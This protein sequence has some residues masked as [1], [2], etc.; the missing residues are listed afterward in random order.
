MQIAPITLEGDIVRL[1]PL[2]EDHLAALAEVAFD[3]AIW[4]WTRTQYMRSQEELWIWMEE[5]LTRAAT[6]KE[7]P[8]V[9]CHKADNCVA[10]STRFM[11][12][13][14]HHH[15]LELGGTWLAAR[16]QR[17]GINVEA[18]YLQLRY[19]FETLGAMRVAFKTHHENFKSQRAIEALGTVKEGTF[20]NHMI[21]PDGSI[22]HSVWYSV[23]REDWPAVKANLEDRMAKYRK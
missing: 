18:K 14:A 21:M 13:D 3:A 20:R 4:R 11:D 12:I 2:R 8:W 1:E 19:A 23:I 15:T 5:A 10:G 17:S 22:R 6:G 16:Y 7:L 9:T